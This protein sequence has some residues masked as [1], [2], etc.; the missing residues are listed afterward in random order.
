MA[1]DPELAEFTRR[2]DKC[3]WSWYDASTIPMPKFPR[4]HI[5]VVHT[6][7]AELAKIREAERLAE[8]AKT[9]EQRLAAEREKQARRE[10]EARMI[11]EYEQKV[12]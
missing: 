4:E 12:P 3:G 2:V 10:A 8:A 5:R 11:Q 6:T 9:E 1:L 7:N